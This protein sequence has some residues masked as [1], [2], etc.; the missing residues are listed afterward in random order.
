MMK[1]LLEQWNKFLNETRPSDFIRIAAADRGED[2]TVSGVRD[3]ERQLF[4]DLQDKLA[5]A[6]QRKDVMSGRAKELADM[7]MA[8]LDKL[9][10]E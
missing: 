6:A 1:L 4:L 2:M 10:G 5:T 3:E 9:A 8:E 7:L